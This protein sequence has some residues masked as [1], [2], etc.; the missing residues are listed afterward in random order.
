MDL[1][2]QEILQE[3][4]SYTDISLCIQRNGTVAPDAFELRGPHSCYYQVYRRRWDRASFHL[5]SPE[6]YWVK[7]EWLCSEDHSRA[8]LVFLKVFI[9]WHNGNFH[10]YK[11]SPWNIVVFP[12]N[13]AIPLPDDAKLVDIAN[14][15]YGPNS[16]ESPLVIVH[17]DQPT[18]P[19]FDRFFGKRKEVDRAVEE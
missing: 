10:R 7:P 6:W 11:L 16:Q 13:S 17:K 14:G 4:T 9:A 15:L 8:T 2:R 5:L 18:S 19:I 12:S 3:M 1:L